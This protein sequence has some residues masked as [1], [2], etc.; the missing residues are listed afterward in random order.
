VLLNQQYEIS[1]ISLKAIS[2]MNFLLGM[3]FIV[4]HKFV[5]VLH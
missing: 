2:T 1:L 3:A 5:C 4:F